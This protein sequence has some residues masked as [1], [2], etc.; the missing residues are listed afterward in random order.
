MACP[1][2]GAS[3]LRTLGAPSQL[4]TRHWRPTKVGALHSAC[5]PTAHHMRTV[6]MR[7]QAARD[8]AQWPPRLLVDGLDHGEAAGPRPTR[9][10]G[11]KPRRSWRPAL[12]QRRAIRRLSSPPN[13]RIARASELSGTRGSLHAG[14]V[15][16]AYWRGVG[17][18]SPPCGPSTVAVPPD[19]ELGTAPGTQPRATT[20]SRPPYGKR[21]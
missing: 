12:Y 13:F 14:R 3:S 1:A 16:R 15:Q 21:G 11:S 7:A 10:R 6:R 8:R 2:G 9:S 5:T 19:S 20:P 17:R 18:P 4:H